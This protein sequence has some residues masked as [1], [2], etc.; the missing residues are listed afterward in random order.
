MH[1]SASSIST[2]L[3]EPHKGEPGCKRWWYMRYVEKVP[4]PQ[5][6]KA[7]LGTRCHEIA[8]EDYLRDGKAP[9]RAEQMVIVQNG[10]PRT[11][12]PGRIVS[13]ILH[14]LPP[15]G[16]VQ[17]VE[18]QLNLTY[19]GH[20][21]FG[22][23]DHQD[24]HTVGDL[25][26]TSGLEY[27]KSETDLLID[28]QRRVYTGAR[29]LESDDREVTAQWTYG[30]FDA[31]Q[32]RKVRLNV[33]RADGLAQLDELVPT[34][35]DMATLAATCKSAM[36]VTPTVAKHTCFAFGQV[37]PGTER[38]KPSAKALAVDEK[39]VTK[40]KS[41]AGVRAMT[42]PALLRL[43]AARAAA[44]AAPAASEP[45]ETVAPIAPVE[46]TA[47]APVAGAINPPGEACEPPPDPKAVKAAEKEAAAVAKAEAKAARPDA[48]KRGRGR[49][50][51]AL[52][53]AELPSA[54]ATSDVE[55]PRAASL[56][57]LYV[58]C[59]PIKGTGECEH[60]EAS[61]LI[62]EA[63]A[64][65][66]SELDVPHYALVDFGR[67]R[68]ALHVALKHVLATRPAPF[69]V[70]LSTRSACGMDALQALTEA[71]FVVVRG[72]A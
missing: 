6:E 34:L 30:T 13:N 26:F 68:G 7:K 61:E 62:E 5:G 11:Y 63:N 40:I 48:P 60:V 71:A 41:I 21:L 47:A 43:R 72:A 28:V 14:H 17:R 67:G 1:H 32:S 31:K 56:Q 51:K 25:K 64:I 66:A 20:E 9:N 39:T 59:F 10:S 55:P 69:N 46:T 3:G 23:V 37:C 29:F 15:A 22:Y 42:S 70:L 53:L 57:V 36:D 18:E 24:E 45:V 33:L 8:L 4:S 27:A 44:T 35:D 16:S 49:P 58:D 50:P 19:R 65:V 54:P 12:Y 52:P 2:Y 38:C